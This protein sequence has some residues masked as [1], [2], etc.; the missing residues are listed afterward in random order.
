MPLTA[1]SLAVLEVLQKSGIQPLTSF[2]PAEGRAYFDAVFATKPEDQEAVASVRELSIPVSGGRIRARL[3]SPKAGPLPVLVHYHGGGWVLMGLSTHEGYCRQL[4]NAAGVAVLAVE[5]RKAPEFKAPIPV[6]DC[7]AALQWVRANATDLNVD[8][9]HL[10]VVGDSAGANLAAAVT[11]LARDAGIPIQCQVLTYPAVDATL[12][13]ASIQENATAPL[14]GAAEMQWFYGHYLDG[15][16]VDA[17][18][19]LVS[20]LFAASHANLPAAF[21]ATAQFD[22]LRDEGEAYARKLLEAGVAVSAKRYL[23]V[24]HGFM[25]MSKIIPEGRQLLAAQVDFLKHAL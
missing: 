23:G 13:S 10:G 25:L 12:S 21:I 15:A 5:Y 7:Y 9:N 20:P 6:D 3:Y 24:F 2:P 4:A 11:L 16:T 1:E 17:K 8:I 14:L 19:P 18:N 22:P